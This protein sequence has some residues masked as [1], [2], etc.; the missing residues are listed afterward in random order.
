MRSLF[1]F[2]AL[3]SFIL[4]LN[5]CGNFILEDFLYNFHLREESNFLNCHWKWENIEWKLWDVFP[6]DFHKNK[7]IEDK[8]DFSFP[9]PSFYCFCFTLFSA[10]HY[11]HRIPFCHSILFIVIGFYLSWICNEMWICAKWLKFLTAVCI[12]HNTGKC[13]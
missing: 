5:N 4:A 11:T 2:F 7:K 8:V 12:Y 1:F 9:F 13:Y 10:P 3:H 6:L